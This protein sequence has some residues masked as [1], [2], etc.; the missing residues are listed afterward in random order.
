MIIHAAGESST[1]NLPPHTYAVAL[2]VP[3]EAALRVLARRLGMAGI[4]HRGI[5][6]T[7]PPWNGQMMAIGLYPEQR[8][9]LKKL[10]SSLPLLK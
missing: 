6:E 1:G 7:D 9:K 10:L 8:S 4:L 2:T 3:D 5:Y